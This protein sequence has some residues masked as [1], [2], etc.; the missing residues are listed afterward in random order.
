MTSAQ[1]S[2]ASGLALATGAVVFTLHIVLRS[3]LT[4]G[5][6]GETT[7]FVCHGLW[8]PVNAP[9]LADGLNQYPPMLV[10]F[11]AALLAEAAGTRSSRFPSSAASWTRAGSATS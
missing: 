7:A 11:G 2:R 3:A 9:Q 5:A 1:L 4:A 8:V 6:G 10:A